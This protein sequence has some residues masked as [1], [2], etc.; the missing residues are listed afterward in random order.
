MDIVVT[1]RPAEIAPGKGLQARALGMVSSVVIAVASAAPAYSLAATL[2]LV[3]VAVGLQSPVIVVLAFVPMLFTALGYKEL[4]EVDPDCGTTFTWAARAFGPYT[5]WM[6]GWAIVVADVLVMASL[7]QIAGQYSFLLLGAGGIGHNATSVWVLA[8]GVGFIAVMTWLCVRGLGV[9]ARVQRVLLSIEVAMLVVLA[10]VALVRVYLGTAPQ[11][12]LKPAWNWFNPM[13]IGSASSF[14]EAT[15]LMVFIYWGWDSSVSINEETRDSAF[16]PGRAAV[17]ATVLLVAVYTLLTVASQAFAGVGTEGIG[18]AN[19][20]NVGDVL[21]TVGAA[22]FGEGWIGTVLT[23][24]LLLMVLTS[25]AASTQTTILP[26]ARTTFAMAVFKA[27]PD[28]FARVHPRYLTPTVSTIAMGA[29]SA[30]VY[31]GFNFISGGAVI[32]DAVTAIGVSVGLY[33]GLTGLAC[34]WLFRHTLMVSPR[35]LLVRGVLP[36]LGGVLLI[37][38]V[39]WT[40]V[41]V[42]APDAGSTSWTM[43]LAPHWQ[44]GG[45]FIIGVG[46]LALGIPLMLLMAGARPAFFRGEVLVKGMPGS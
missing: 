26:T 1:T 40:A 2:G 6:G 32:S 34:A 44:I 27:L 46:S 18:L 30:A 19:P 8:V 41:T 38:A 15:L 11:G 14:V 23:H 22:V 35:H 3:V 25:A 13:E 10:A 36:A 21:S 9:S 37:F 39:A 5:A 20:E 12:S 45:V 42:W 17:L 28:S 24:L 29:V 43:P 33:Y 7:A 16:T 31:V 4:N